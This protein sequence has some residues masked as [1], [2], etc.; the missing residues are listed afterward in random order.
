V[1]RT[2]ASPRMAGSQRRPAR[3][4]LTPKTQKARVGGGVPLSNA[5]ADPDCTRTREAAA[6][7][8]DSAPNDA[9]PRLRNS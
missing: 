7:S 6:I 3:R 4:L 5:C 2:V 9:G 8:S 1:G